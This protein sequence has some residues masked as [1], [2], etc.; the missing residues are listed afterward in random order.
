M[1]EEEPKKVSNAELCAMWLNDEIPLSDYMRQLKE[2]PK[3]QEP[4][5]HPCETGCETMR[6]NGKRAC[7]VC[8]YSVDG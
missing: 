1:D 7:L 6:R 8:E 4:K 2:S 3:P 5:Y